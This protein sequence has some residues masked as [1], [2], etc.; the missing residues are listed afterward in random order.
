MTLTQTLSHPIRLLKAVAAV[1]RTTIDAGF[2]VRG[3]L[4]VFVALSAGM[5]AH[6]PAAGVLASVAALYVG[7]AAAPGAYRTRLRAMLVTTVVDAFS[8]FVGSW[9]GSDL[10]AIVILTAI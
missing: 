2:A 3:T 10:S 8:A 6:R 5:L 1:D 9:A 4:G 7:V